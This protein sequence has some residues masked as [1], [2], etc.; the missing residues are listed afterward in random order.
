MCVCVSVCVNVCERYIIRK[1]KSIKLNVSNYYYVSLTVKHQSFV[2]TQLD[3]QTVLFQ[4]I[5]FSIN[6]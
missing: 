5:Q 1:Q 2:Y 6:H 3:Q 4:I